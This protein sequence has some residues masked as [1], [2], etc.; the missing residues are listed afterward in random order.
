MFDRLIDP[1]VLRMLHP[2]RRASRPLPPALALRAEDVTIPAR[3]PIKAWLLRG[4]GHPV[5]TVVLVHGWGS[6]SGRMAAPAVPILE[7]GMAALLVDLPGHGRT[8]SVTTYNA[9]LMVDDVRAARDW[10]ESRDELRSL[11]AALLGYSFGGL[12][13]YVAAS[14]DSRWRAL[15]VMAAPVGAMEAARLYL[16]GKGLPGGWLDGMVRRSFTRAAGVDPTSFDAE[17]NLGSIRVPVM[18]VHGEEDEVVPVSHAVRLAACVPHG[19]ATLWR[20]PG[21]NH[22][23]LLADESVAARVATFLYE[24]LRR[25]GEGP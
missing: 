22:S 12:G 20:V 6:D 16:D 1:L 19:L 3:T 9:A 18:I 10:I 17:R 5:G 15:V 14:R 21:A 24:N 2:P 8:G 25:A 23:A 4:E 7:R 13:S 11:P